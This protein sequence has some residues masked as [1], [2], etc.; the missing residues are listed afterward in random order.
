M[1]GKISYHRKRGS[2]A[3]ASCEDTEATAGLEDRLFIQGFMVMLSE[4]YCRLALAAEYWRPSFFSAGLS[5]QQCG[6]FS[7]W[8]EVWGF[9]SLSIQLGGECYIRSVI[10]KEDVY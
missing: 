4:G 5:L 6:L 8:L 10:S 7:K 2:T 9:V 3:V 1:G